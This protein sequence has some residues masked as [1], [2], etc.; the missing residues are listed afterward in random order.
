MRLVSAI[1]RGK[2][3]RKK[4]V[5]IAVAGLDSHSRGAMVVAEA[6]RDGGMEVVY[7]G[8]RQTPEEIVKAAIQESV[9]VVGVSVHSGAQ[10]T[11][12]PKVLNLLRENKAGDIPV[13]VGGV[14]PKQDVVT[15]KDVGVREVFGVGTDTR[16][17]V[18]F[19]QDITT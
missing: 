8:L 9:D 5:L 19:I 6:L 13:I 14:V 12:M 10:L 17:I 11:I 7:T 4:R 2:L 1:K 3:G 16:K 18:R 15:L